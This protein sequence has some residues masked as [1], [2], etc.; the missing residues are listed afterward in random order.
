MI[1]FEGYG[2]RVPLLAQLAQTLESATLAALDGIRHIDRVSFRAKGAN[3][4]LD[5]AT[6]EAKDYEHPLVEIE[7]QVAGRI[8][9]LFL[10]DIHTVVAAL[11]KR[12]NEVESRLKEPRDESAFGYESH[13]LVCMIPPDCEPF[14]WASVED[15]PKTFELQVRTLFMHA[16]PNPSTTWATSRIQTCHATF[17]G[18][19]LGP[20]RQ[21]GGLT[22]RYSAF[23][24]GTA[25]SWKGFRKRAGRMPITLM[26]TSQKGRRGSHWQG[27]SQCADDARVSTDL[28]FPVS[29]S[30]GD[31]RGD[32]PPDV[33]RSRRQCTTSAACTI[34]CRP[35][36]C[37]RSL[38]RRGRIASAT[39][40]ST[41][42]VRRAVWF[43]SGPI[44][45]D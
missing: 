25:G 22:G 1:L 2:R 34:S 43:G 23:S 27:P 3:S 28:P 30:D 45:E 39:A 44:L 37:A 9:V 18:S 38:A 41:D 31:G 20:Q 35:A 21:H 17:V 8:L 12:F 6:S 40:H 5:K 16:W 4:F 29:S 24:N 33:R 7:D 10:E 42:Y 15:P 32:E 11:Q 19:G 14:G 13:H 26:R 36:C